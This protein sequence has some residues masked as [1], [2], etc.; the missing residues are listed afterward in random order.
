MEFNQT[1]S[2]TSDYPT[3]ERVY[4]LHMPNRLDTNRTK[5]VRVFNSVCAS[6]VRNLAEH[7]DL[8]KPMC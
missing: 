1:D 5:V 4:L 8:W 2:I 3:Y 7:Y 6:L